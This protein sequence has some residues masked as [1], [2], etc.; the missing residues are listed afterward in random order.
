MIN[1][2]SL[3]EETTGSISARFHGGSGTSKR[4]RQWG[5][6]YYEKESVESHHLMEKMQH[7]NRSLRDRSSDINEKL[8]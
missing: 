5:G 3:M 6:E 8:S 1:S 7:K 4:W 2:G